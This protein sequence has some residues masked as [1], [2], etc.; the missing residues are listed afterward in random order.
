MLL[1]AESAQIVRLA[2]LKSAVEFSKSQADVGLTMSL[3]DVLVVAVRMEAHIID[4]R[5]TGHPIG[6]VGF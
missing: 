2:C 6:K 4:S 1:D 5:T 3:E